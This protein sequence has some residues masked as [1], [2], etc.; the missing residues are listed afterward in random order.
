MIAEG[1]VTTK[2]YTVFSHFD[3][4]TAPETEA[5]FTE[6]GKISCNSGQIQRVSSEIP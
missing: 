2:P 1:R 3:D 6:R 5:S 4:S